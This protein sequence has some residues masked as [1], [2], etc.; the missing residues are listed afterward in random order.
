MT[1]IMF[2]CGALRD[3]LPHQTDSYKALFYFLIKSNQKK[4][5]ARLG[6]GITR[7]EL[8]WKQ[9]KKA[10]VTMPKRNQKG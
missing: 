8:H 10:R 5:V 2:L 7:F 1:V 4:L 3:L 9:T 6:K